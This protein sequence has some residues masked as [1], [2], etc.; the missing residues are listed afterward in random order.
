MNLTSEQV[1]ALATD[2]ASAAAARKLAVPKPWK[3]L[4]Q[5][6]RAMWGECQGSALY[7]VR[8]DLSDMSTKCSCPSRKFPCKHALALLLLAAT[9]GGSF[10]TGAHPE[11]VS[12]WFDK[13]AASA[14][15][16]GPLITSRFL[17]RTWPRP[18]RNYWSAG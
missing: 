15:R 1:L 18:A 6:D 4:G 3:N 7:Q 5:S 16:I 10:A 2:P 17:K 9:S 11:W 8:V 14:E 12:E 13:R